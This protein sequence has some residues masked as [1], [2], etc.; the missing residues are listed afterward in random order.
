[1]LDQWGLCQCTSHPSQN[2]VWIIL[3]P[4]AIDSS[5]DIYVAFC[6]SF[7]LPYKIWQDF[8]LQLCPILP[9]VAEVVVRKCLRPRRSLERASSGGNKVLQQFLGQICTVTG[10]SHHI[11]HAGA[12]DLC[13]LVGTP[14]PTPWSGLASCLHSA[15]QGM[16][17]T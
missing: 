5:P 11:L 17:V 15:A 8:C 12:L 2:K 14:G 7:S 10:P 9:P 1:M 6:S 13:A 4:K 16:T 3:I